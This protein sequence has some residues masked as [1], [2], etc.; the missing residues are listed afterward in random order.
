MTKC[1]RCGSVAVEHVAIREGGKYRELHLCDACAVA[2]VEITETRH[3]AR[4]NRPQVRDTNVHDFIRQWA[5][6]QRLLGR[7]LSK[8][9]LI[10]ILDRLFD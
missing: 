8:N 6:Q 3:R 9:E 10:H 4:Q 7:E 5:S 2:E 1:E